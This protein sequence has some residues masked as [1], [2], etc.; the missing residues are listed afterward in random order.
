MTEKVEY[1]SAGYNFFRRND[2]DDFVDHI[3]L[4]FNSILLTE[5]HKRDIN[6]HVKDASVRIN[7]DK[8]YNA[9]LTVVARKS[10]NSRKIKK[11]VSELE[12]VIGF[13]LEKTKI[14]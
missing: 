4:E 11:A 2:M 9:A 6:L 13:K 7:R 14:R 1:E 5:D 12:R 8:E 10:I 3:Y